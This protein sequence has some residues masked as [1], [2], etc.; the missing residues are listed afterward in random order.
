VRIAL[1]GDYDESV[2]AHRAIPV[3]LSLASTELDLQVDY[4]WVN[5]DA[6]NFEELRKFDAIW[7][8]PASPYKNMENVLGAIEIARTANIP[9][10]GTC[11][12]Y[13]HAALEYARNALGYTEAEN[14]EVNPAAELPLIASLSCKLYDE[15][16]SIVLDPSSKLVEVYKKS[17]ITEEYFCG[18]GVNADY[19]SI[20]NGSDFVFTGFDREGDPRCFELQ[21]HLFFIGTAFQPERSALSGS[22]HPLIKAFVAAAAKK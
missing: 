1:V 17:E 16:A 8:V 9:F 22:S 20:F 18:F 14:S 21:R 6:V 5:S 11:G 13:Q 4:C 15:K 12:G 2:T 10:L 7:C 3:A 19:L